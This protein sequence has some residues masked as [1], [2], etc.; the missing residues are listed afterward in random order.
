MLDMKAQ[1]IIHLFINKKLINIFDNI[2]TIKPLLLKFGKL[3][4]LANERTWNHD[5]ESKY[6]NKKIKW[7]RNNV[8]IIQQH[9]LL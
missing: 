3:I 2:N 1:T 9:N 5:N 4:L 7:D 8:K 6:S